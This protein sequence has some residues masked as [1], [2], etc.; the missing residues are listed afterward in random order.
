MIDCRIRVFEK[1]LD[2]DVVAAAGNALPCL[3]PHHR[4]AVSA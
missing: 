2:G 1:T 4:A 3:A